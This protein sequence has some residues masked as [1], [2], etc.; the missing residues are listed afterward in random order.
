MGRVKTNQYHIQAMSFKVTVILP[1]TDG[2]ISVKVERPADSKYLGHEIDP[3]DDGP[4]RYFICFYT[5]G[6]SSN[7]EADTYETGVEHFP[8]HPISTSFTGLVVVQ[9]AVVARDRKRTR[10]GRVPEQ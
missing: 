9:N 4:A 10:N 8:A 3:L 1:A 2:K 7:M 5:E 6:S